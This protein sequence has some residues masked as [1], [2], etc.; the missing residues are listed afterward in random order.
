MR[1]GISMRPG[2]LVIWQ[3]PGSVRCLAVVLYEIIAYGGGRTG[4]WRV[5]ADDAHV[6]LTRAAACTTV[7]EAP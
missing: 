5:L 3:T 7:V 2:D 6:H 1:I 4:W